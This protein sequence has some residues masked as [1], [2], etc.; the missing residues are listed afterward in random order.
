MREKLPRITAVTALPEQR[1][2]IDFEDGWTATV[3]LGEF[4]E[5]F[6]VLAPL[7]DRTLFRKTKVEE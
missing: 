3:S 4:I 2:S 1:L 6:P 7:G 5:A